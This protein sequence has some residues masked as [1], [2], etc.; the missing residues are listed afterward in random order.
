VKGAIFL[1]RDNTIVHDPG[2]LA[3]PHRVAFMPGAIDGLVSMARQRWPLIVVSNQSGIARGLY[4]PSAFHAVM[5]RIHREL[6]PL[7]V[8]LTAAY[9]CPHHPDVTG[10]CACRKPGPAMYEAAA[11]DYGI[12]LGRSWYVGNRVSDAAPALRFGGKGLIVTG[13]TNG[14]EAVAGRTAGFPVVGDLEVA[15]RHIG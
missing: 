15:A 8:R 14:T 6:E 9:Y 7:G 10:P 4:P 13:D 12:D 3:D 5:D 1:D 11:R 2:Y